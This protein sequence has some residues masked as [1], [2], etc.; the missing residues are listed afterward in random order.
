MS[1]FVMI[2][3]EGYS[4]LDRHYINSTELN[5]GLFANAHIYTVIEIATALMLERGDMTPEQTIADIQL[6]NDEL[7]VK[8]V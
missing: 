4:M 7:W 1:Q 2:A 3:P 8:L 6:V 5:T